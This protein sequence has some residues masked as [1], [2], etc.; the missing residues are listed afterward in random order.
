MKLTI[1]NQL[2]T[3][4]QDTTVEGS[5]DDCLK[6]IDQL[7]QASDN[8]NANKREFDKVGKA[9]EN[10]IKESTENY[11]QKLKDEH[12]IDMSTEDKNTIY[13]S[14]TVGGMLDILHLDLDDDYPAHTMLDFQR[15]LQ[16]E[17]NKGRLKIK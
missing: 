11:L 14:G 3:T 10:K 1:H 16:R 5:V 2:G 13:L 9:V 8:T 7:K 6:A 17:V 15:A 12:L 4:G